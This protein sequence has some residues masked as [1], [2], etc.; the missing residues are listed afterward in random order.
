MSKKL[1]KLP[2]YQQSLFEEHQPQKAKRQRID[3]ECVRVSTT[4]GRV[5][6]GTLI[7]QNAS[8]FKRASAMFI[9]TPWDFNIVISNKEGGVKL[10]FNKHST[11]NCEIYGDLLCKTIT[12]Y[13]YD[14]NVIKV[15]GQDAYDIAASSRFNDDKS[16]LWIS[17]ER[18]QS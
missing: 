9:K 13:C 2:E 7:S 15:Y 16:E 8:I 6:L 12:D 1:T 11:S 14:D 5:K 10:S 3:T 18:R 4:Y 17:I